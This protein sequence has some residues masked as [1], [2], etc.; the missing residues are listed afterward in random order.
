MFSANISEIMIGLMCIPNLCLHKGIQL[1]F[2]PS[3]SAVSRQLL[4]AMDDKTEQIFHLVHWGH[5]ISEKKK[6]K[7]LVKRG[8]GT[9]EDTMGGE[10]HMGE[11]HFCRV[12]L[13]LEDTKSILVLVD[14]GSLIQ[15][16]MEQ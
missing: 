9:L 16:Y 13:S 14:Q 12:G 2:F 11:R 15:Q 1:F 7:K 10:T 6:K 3:C 5:I 8:G 4:L